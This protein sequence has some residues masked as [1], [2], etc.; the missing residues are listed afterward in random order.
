MVLHMA[1]CRITAYI[2]RFYFNQLWPNFTPKIS[3]P[4]YIHVQTIY[5]KSLYKP[6]CISESFITHISTYIR[7]YSL[8]TGS[9]IFK[10]LLYFLILYFN[11][12]SPLAPSKPATPNHFILS[13]KCTPFYNNCW[14]NIYILYIL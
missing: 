12:I 7:C 5:L 8:T 9:I 1:C 2:S 11:F 14:Y 6:Y 4:T 13:F 3:I 10:L